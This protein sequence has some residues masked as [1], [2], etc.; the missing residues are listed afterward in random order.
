MTHAYLHIGRGKT[1][2]SAIQYFLH[3]HRK[4]L[5][6]QS[7][8]V[9]TTPGAVRH[10]MLSLYAKA[11]HKLEGLPQWRRLGQRFENPTAMRAFL[12]RELPAEIETA[13]ADSIVLSDEALFTVNQGPVLRILPPSVQKITFIAYLRRQ[14]ERLFSSYKQRVRAHGE[15]RTL[16]DWL[17]SVLRGV[18][19]YRRLTR[20]VRDYPQHEVIVRPYN[21]RSFNAESV[22]Y[23]FNSIIGSP[24]AEDM[25]RTRNGAINASLDAYATEW[26]R[27]RNVKHGTAPDELQRQLTALSDGPDLTL[28]HEEI[29]SIFKRYKRSNQRLVHKFV[30]DRGEYLLSEP[31]A[32]AGVLQEDITD[33][34]VRRVGRRV[35]ELQRASGVGRETVWADSPAVHT[36]GGICDITAAGLPFRF[37]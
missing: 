10:A 22:I 31:T 27:R 3:D 21:R 16:C 30:P 33:E 25:I 20:L 12:A 19:D 13:R 6:A 9:P 28:P 24:V 15:T 1:G 8:F 7:I 11:D 37:L 34:E 14:D 35:Q 36:A 17:K 4:E 18:P 26:L 2:T 5:A 23:D 29:V 32:R